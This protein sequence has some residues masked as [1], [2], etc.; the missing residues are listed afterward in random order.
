[1]ADEDDQW[2]FSLDDLPDDGESDREASGTRDDGDWE[3]GGNVA[4]SVLGEE[5]ELEPG[6]ISPENAFF[7]AL[8][9]LSAIAVVLVVAGVI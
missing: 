5:E 3:P 6:Q 7:V 1:M 9:A 2:R 8:G 4:G